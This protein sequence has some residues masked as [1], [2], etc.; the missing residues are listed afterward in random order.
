M[1]KLIYLFSMLV[2]LCSCHHKHQPKSV[3]PIDRV[4]VVDKFIDSDNADMSAKYEDYTWYEAQVVL[5]SYLDA[6]YNGVE[7]VTN[8]FQVIA[9]DGDPHV[10]RY[11]HTLTSDV[12][13]DTPGFWIEDFP[14]E[15]VE[16]SFDQALYLL[17]EVN[18]VKPHS[19]QVCLRRPIG[20]KACE[21]QWV[22]GNIHSTLFIDAV[23]GK[24][25]ETNPAFPE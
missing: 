2:L 16:V 24:F 3:E 21:A 12:I 19:K 17:N 1:K 14:L 13:E 9:E 6:E 11:N 7:S 10:I 15:N 5:N 4:V 18:I 25:S 8:V 22:F 20:P 23:D